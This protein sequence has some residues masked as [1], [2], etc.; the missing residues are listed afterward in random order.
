MTISS[1]KF[2]EALRHFPAGVTIVTIKSPSQDKSAWVNGVS[3]CLYFARASSGND[4][5]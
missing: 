2:R 5:H 1:E 4:C 3:V